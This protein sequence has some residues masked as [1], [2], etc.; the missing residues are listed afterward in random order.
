[1]TLKIP[2]IQLTPTPATDEARAAVGFR[3]NDRAGTRHKLGGEPDWQQGS[4]T[5]RC[6]SCSLQMTFYGQLDSVGDDFVIGDCGLIYVFVCFECLTTK[7][8]LQSS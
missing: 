2:E 6:A 3:W 7:A 1:M 8:V 4:E 5:P